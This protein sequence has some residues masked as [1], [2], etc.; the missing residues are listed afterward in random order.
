M[1]RLARILYCKLTLAHWREAFGVHHVVLPLRPP[2][3]G[4]RVLFFCKHCGEQ[5]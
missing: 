2:L 3:R 5:A 1:K 4:Q